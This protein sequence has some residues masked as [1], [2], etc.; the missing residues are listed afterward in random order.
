MKSDM[1]RFVQK[2]FL[3]SVLNEMHDIAKCKQDEPN[4]NHDYWIGYSQASR[5]LISMFDNDDSKNLVRGY[6][7]FVQSVKEDIGGTHK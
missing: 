7:A 2:D 1:L 4:E 3:I 6:D 5:E